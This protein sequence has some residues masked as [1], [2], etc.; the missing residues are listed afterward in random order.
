MKNLDSQKLAVFLETENQQL[1]KLNDI[2]IKSIE[3]EKL[4]SHKLLEFEEKHPTFANRLADKIAEFG[5]SW[6]F[7]LVFL[8]FITTWIA[9]NAYL[10][11][12]VTSDKADIKQRKISVLAPIGTALIGFRK[13]QQVAWHVPSGKKTFTIVDVSN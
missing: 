9:I 7:I 11:T 2:V 13:G 10:L 1:K 6:K 8:F 12:L 3:E 5:G 4:L